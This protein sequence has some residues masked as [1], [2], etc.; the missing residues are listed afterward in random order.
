MSSVPY[1]STVG[2]IMYATVCTRPDIS[3]AVSVVSRYMAYPERQHWKAVK[4]ILRYLQGTADMGLIFDK[5]KMEN[6]IIGF[7]DS[8]YAGGLDKR[9]SLTG[10]LFTL[11]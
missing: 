1:S 10:Y 9:R 7:V 11:S 5:K 3:H 4:W 2:S 6:S 8:D